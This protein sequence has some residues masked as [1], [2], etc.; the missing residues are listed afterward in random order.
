MDGLIGIQIVAG[1]NEAASIS[2]INSTLRTIGQRA[3]SIK[4]N[5]NIDDK[6]LGTLQNFNKEMQNLTKLTQNLD[7]NV[8]KA[9]KGGIV[10]E[11]QVESVKKLSVETEKL[12]NTQRKT[13]QQVE[14]GNKNQSKSY[15]QLTKDFIKHRETVN[16]YDEK[17]KLVG[18][19]INRSDSDGI[20]RVTIK[21]NEKGEMESYKISQS[22]ERAIKQTQQLAK[23]TSKLTQKQHELR[24]VLNNISQTGQTPQGYTEG[25][26][27]KIN[28]SQNIDQLNKYETKLK[29]IETI[30]KK[31]VANQQALVKAEQSLTIARLDAQN[32]VNALEANITSNAFKKNQPVI[33]R[34]LKDMNEVSA[35]SPNWQ[36]QVRM[37]NK[38]FTS[39]T[40]EIA[41][42]DKGLARFSGQMGAAM[43]RIPIYAVGV[44]AMYAPITALRDALRQ[45]VE[46]DSQMTVLDRVSNGQIKTN[47]AM[48]DSIGIAER[49]GNT[50]AEVNEGLINFARQGY[51]GADLTAITE[52]ATVM[53]NVSD[54][55]IEDS[56]SSLTAAMKAFNIE[57]EDSIRIVDSLNE[58]DNNYS[59]TTKQLAQSIQ[60]S[61]GVANTFGVS[62]EKL[63]GY[64]TAMGE[65]SREQ[66]NQLGNRLK[67]VISRITTM[68]ESITA[69]AD[70][71]ISTKIGDEVRDVG[72]VLDDLGGK[73]H[74]LSKEQQQHLGVQLAGRHQ[75]S[76][77]LIL[78]QNYERA[79]EATATAE[80]STGSAMKENEKY[81]DSYEAKINKVKNAW[82]EA[83]ISLQ[84]DFLGDA[85]V[86]FTEVATSGIG[87]FSKLIDKVGLLPTVFG[88][89]TLAISLFRLENT[90]LTGMYITQWFGNLSQLLKTAVTSYR[91]GA[92]A[93][94]EF[95]VANQTMSTGVKAQ[96][97]G[98]KD[99]VKSLGVTLKAAFVGLGQFAMGA[100]LPIAGFMALGAAISFVTG[101]VVDAKAEK[102][103]NIKATNT[104]LKSVQDE[105]DTIAELA[106][107]Y[108]KLS[109]VGT[110]RNNSQDERYVEIQNELA[111]LLP[112][113]KEGEDA[114]GNAILRN[115]DIVKAHIEE[116][117]KLNEEEREN[118][119]IVAG[120]KISVAINDSKDSEETIESLKKRR[121]ELEK[122]LEDMK[123]GFSL[124]ALN[125]GT[126]S[127]ESLEKELGEIGDQIKD[128]M[129]KQA[130]S[131]SDLEKA[132]LDLIN[133]SKLDQTDIS[134]IAENSAEI[135]ASKED[136]ELYNSSL[137]WLR[138]N[139]NSGFSLDKIDITSL[140]NLKNEIEDIGDT[141][142][143]GDKDWKN[144]RKSLLK[145]IP[146]SQQVSEVLSGLRYSQD[147]L[148]LSAKQHGTSVD[149]STPKL[150]KYG[151]I[152]GWVN[153]KVGDLT[154]SEGE[155]SD[156]VDELADSYDKAIEDIGELNR[157]V[158]E[159]DEGHGLSAETIGTIISKYSE[160]LPYLNDEKELRKQIEK[161]VESEGQVAKEVIY[162]KLKNDTDYY[163]QL[164][165]SNN[166]AF[167][168]IK[169]A[170]DVDFKDFKNLA[171]AKQAVENE[172][173]SGL[174]KSWNNYVSSTSKMTDAKLNSLVDDNLKFNDK[175]REAWGKM[176]QEEQ[177]NFGTALA[178]QQQALKQMTT[179]FQKI[180]F[181][182]SN[183]NFDTIGIDMEKNSKKLK[184]SAK[185]VGKEF[186]ASRYIADKY[187][188]ALEGLNLEL[189]KQ[190]KIQSKYPE[191]SKQYRKSLEDEIK[192]L[193]SKD[194]LL[195]S[196]SKELAQQIKNGNIINSGVVSDKA[197][198]SRSKYT[199]KY[200]KEINSSASKYGVDPFLIASIIKQESNFNSRAVSHAGARGLMQLMPATARGLGVKNS[201]NAAQNIDGGTK[202][203]AQQL[204]AFG[205]DLNKALAAYNAG[206]G[207]VRKYGGIP[208]FKETQNYIKQVNRNLKAFGGAVGDTSKKMNDTSN[209]YLDKFKVTSKFG[210]QE[211]FRG[212]PHK[213][214]DLANGKQGDLVKALRGGKVI[215]AN[216]SKSA[217][218]WVVIQQDDGNVA[219]YMHMQKGLK[220]KAGQN[221]KAG[222]T[223]G[224][225]GNTGNSTGAHLHIGLEKDG[226]A[227]DPMPYIQALSKE[228]AQ[229]LA[230]VDT[231]KS[232]FNGLQKDILDVQ[233]RIE[234]LYYQIVESNIAVFDRAKDRVNKKLAEIDY[235]QMLYTEESKE[236]VTQQH[237]KEY[238]LREQK[239]HE[240][241]AI[242]YIEK[243]IKSN[244]NLTKAQKM[245]LDDE[246]WER[247]TQFWDI[248]RQILDERI[249]MA[250][251]AMDVYKRALEAQKDVALQAVDDLISEIDKK[252][253]ERKYKRDL[254]NKQTDRQEIMDEIN[255]WGLDDSDAGKKRVKELTEQLQQMDQDID[256]MVHDRNISKRKESL[257]EEKEKITIKY[258]DLLNDE[259]AFNKMR[260]DMINGNTSSI[261]KK[262]ASFSTDI[263]KMT[264]T[265]GKSMVNNLQDA[266]RAVNQYM[267]SSG[268]KAVKPAKFDTGGLTGSFSGG[269]AAIL[270]E[271][272]IVLNKADTSNLLKAIDFTRDMFS[273]FKAPSTPKMKHNESASKVVQIDKIELHNNSTGSAI[274]DGKA[275]VSEF[276]RGV[277]LRGGNI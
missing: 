83:T 116:L 219:K 196:Q 159:L 40:Q 77:F 186:E 5:V 51:R 112:T 195:N 194:G 192:L 184:D 16:R 33:Q 258:D 174:T 129:S 252:E 62:M 237:K 191:Y 213:G 152:I 28:M 154:D 144:Y 148:A 106:D 165:S 7:S 229:S 198:S 1:L 167:K 176:S 170:Y 239:K 201:F 150:N 233:D 197:G 272:E 250:E 268:N 30:S 24:K 95:G 134:W 89:A 108:E 156:A 49:L 155:A 45:I 74:S 41:K 162:E 57:A 53:G 46:L 99:S 181:E 75:L 274:S 234:E 52:V 132:Y 64:S 275:L 118:A 91:G 39:Q 205:G 211:G 131:V 103:A 6:T 19:T 242:K 81:L 104:S 68:D 122:S 166:S 255:Q 153:G 100:L 180:T 60:K 248:E 145:I 247:Q 240:A 22:N 225:V 238:A 90:R 111:Q 66:G 246:L 96:W 251:Q 259:R 158:E 17:G 130:E 270:H 224:K 273:S 97:A 210:Q 56:A 67:T 54:L 141:T 55:S 21:A 266:I 209:Y 182:S 72:D 133:N 110:N 20:N 43:A 164:L 185:E 199:G 271:K 63:I 230:D 73:W 147:E 101:K 42:L 10:D 265:L 232:E 202:Y 151:E 235:R 200:A 217:G 183:I 65:I 244:K 169:N 231:A 76:G 241:D 38:D 227:I 208:P 207:N 126:F 187:R 27:K 93:A 44:A 173:L 212:A 138:E 48:E 71:G 105:K 171:E 193:K 127:K 262:L 31:R 267:G 18:Q 257:E 179:D 146:D 163:Q 142:S 178:Q 221:V 140:V 61:A 13:S 86:G 59:I 128:K 215:T 203:I 124:S 188:E 260:S 253:D 263:A 249:K 256:D 172:L 79:L 261:K 78:M 226:V 107:E 117:K 80:N 36:H 58:V 14:Q 220:V 143:W 98:L 26:F 8:N 206:A 245:R 264:D 23:E 34:Y 94:R 88:A 25:M 228:S 120:G 254:D 82:T 135:K 177:R 121:N 115:T 70:V 4:L 50:I 114:K 243:Q 109:Q 218:N 32:K 37:L 85:L 175:G 276:V 214:V 15:E 204:K 136:V 149:E 277:K 2:K 125:R 190:N 47:Q 69:L 157:I 9:L 139:L 92:I 123:D 168:N 160:L 223:L 113:V 236:W 102:E 189:E 3:E 35:K 137:E 11:K 161:A 87:I 29:N 12:N 84:E 216:Y 119:R 222:Q 269:K